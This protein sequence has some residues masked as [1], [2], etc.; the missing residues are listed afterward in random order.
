MT[1][2]KGHERGRSRQRG[3][4]CFLN[5]GHTGPSSLLLPV[6][7]VYVYIPTGLVHQVG[8]AE[9]SVAAHVVGAAHVLRGEGKEV[10]GQEGI[11]AR[12]IIP[13]VVEVERIRRGATGG[14]AEHVG[15][16]L[17]DV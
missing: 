10:V 14:N 16:R 6:P 7:V 5:S 15:L 1:E 8:A 4:A 13:Q 3:G 12:S 11:V 2:R 17:V 9:R